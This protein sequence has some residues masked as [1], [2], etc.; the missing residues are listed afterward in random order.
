[1]KFSF[2]HFPPRA[3]ALGVMGALVVAIGASASPV[4]GNLGS[5]LDVIVRAHLAQK[6]AGKAKDRNAD[7]QLLAEAQSYRDNA[8]TN[9]KNQVKV[10]VHLKPRTEKGEFN[11]AS[12]LP[13]SAAVTATDMSYRSGVIEAWINVDDVVALANNKQVSSVILAIKPVLDVGVATSQGVVQ[14]R[15]DQQAQDGTGVTVGTMSDSFAQS[16]NPVT[17]SVDVTTGDLPGPGNPLGNTMPVEV[18]DDPLAGSTDEGR[19]MTQI[20]HDMAPKARLGFATASSGQVSF[21]DNV[22]SLANRAGVT[23]SHAITG[24]S[25]DVIVDDLFYSDSPMFGTSLVG[26]AVNEVAAV[27]VAYFSS[28]GNRP[29]QQAYFSDYRNVSSADLAAALA[30]TNIPTSAFATIPADAYAGGFHN[31]RTDGGQDVA[32]TLSNFIAGQASNMT[33]QW[34]DPFDVTPPTFNPTPFFTDT[35][36]STSTTVPVSFPVTGLV[37]GN[38]YRIT[39]VA[40][41]PP[42]G[43][44]FDAV[45]TVRDPNGTAILTQ[46][47]GTDEEIFFFANLSGTYTVDVVSF[48]AGSMGPFRVSAYTASGTLRVTTDFNLL[49]FRSDTGAFVKSIA[50]KNLLTNQPLEFGSLTFPTANLVQ[51]VIAR[52]N[53]PTA[54]IPASRIRYVNTGFAGPSEY[55][56]YQTPVTYG[57]NHE[58]GAISAAAYSP[59]RPYLPEEFTSPG[60]SFIYFDQDANRL[61]TP[62]TRQKPDVAAMDGANNTFFGGDSASDADTQNNFFG[63]SAAAPH[64]AGVAALVF[65]AHGGPGSVTQPQMRTILQSAGFMHDLDPFFA[66]G[67]ARAGAGKVTLTVQ[68]SHGN[69]SLSDGRLFSTNSPNVVGASYVGPNSVASLSINLQNGNTTGGTESDVVPGLMWDMRA[70]STASTAGFPF[71][72]G[73]TTGTFSMANV[74]PTYSLPATAPAVA[75]QFYQLDLAFSP[76]SFSAG[77]SFSFGSDRDEQRTAANPQLGPTG[78]A[79]GFGNSADLFGATVSI[80][81][82]TIAPGGA[83]FTG[84]TQDGTSFNGTFTNRIGKGYSPLDGYGFINAQDAV[85]APLP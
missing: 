83:T 70:F 61:A 43:N 6:E 62:I 29:A 4:P 85:N 69:F 17:A 42:P 8:I 12:I 9:D 38:Q 23:G 73:T 49:F 72:V 68:A 5:G 31:F 55:N 79:T 59:F 50:A 15:V 54:P 33:F 47:T 11:P 76:G 28:A 58:P 57:H 14:H 32:Q 48:N 46:D 56:S 24:F 10:Y 63:T 20:V 27:G 81:A 74:T 22:R 2:K 52:G 65:Q 1:M 35:G 18:L 66:R 67:Q 39:V 25:A 78:G 82:G 53:V 13:A 60:P 45:V 44:P 3:S 16:T 84:M 7:A 75:G 21:A 19:A 51:L 36:T 34:D 71:T 41:P 30:G 37:A 77:N 80:P 26:R 40:E 64:A